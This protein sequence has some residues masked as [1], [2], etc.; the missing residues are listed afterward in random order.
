MRIPDKCTFAE[1]FNV[2]HKRARSERRVMYH[3]KPEV[4]FFL[5]DTRKHEWRIISVGRCCAQNLFIDGHNHFRKSFADNYS[6]NRNC[7]E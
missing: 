6:C 4:T 2:I 7:H 1:L 3:L 5:C